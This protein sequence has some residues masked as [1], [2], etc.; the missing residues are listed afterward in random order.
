MT[1]LTAFVIA[2]QARAGIR[3]HARVSTPAVTIHVGQGQ[4]IT[5]LPTCCV[6]HEHGRRD[7]HDRI[8]GDGRIASRLSRYHGVEKRALLRLRHQGLCWHEIGRRYGMR[9]A[10]VRAAFTTESW[11][12]YLRHHRVREARVLRVELPRSRGVVCRH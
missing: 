2:D 9:P 1:L 8:D 7:R 11:S 6:T 12:R 3:I 4:R 10:I 5:R